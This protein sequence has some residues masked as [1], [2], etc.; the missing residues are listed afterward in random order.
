MISYL[1]GTLLRK[2]DQQVILETSGVG[3]LVHINASSL[4][5]LPEEG[6]EIE[7]FIYTAVRDDAIVLY[8]FEREQELQFFQKLI[9][10]SGV[11]AKTA[12]A[13]LNH[14][15]DETMNAILTEN[16][17]FLSSIP[18]IGKKLAARIILELKGKLD[19]DLPSVL[20][21]KTGKNHAFEEAVS[22]LLNLGYQR[23]KILQFIREQGQDVKSAEELIAGFLRSV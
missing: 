11:G 19:L 9:Q 21:S 17:A 14:P 2:R 7:F 23:P 5:R 18:G 8:G 4:E 15:I 12:L 6:K 20:S 10:V 13:I 1:K 3:Y 22:A 16:E